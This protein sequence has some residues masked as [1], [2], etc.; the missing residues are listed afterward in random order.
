MFESQRMF[1]PNVELRKVRNGIRMDGV[2]ATQEYK[3]A[4]GRRISWPGVTTRLKK[5]P[6][7]NKE[8]KGRINTEHTKCYITHINVLLSHLCLLEV[9]P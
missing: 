5:Q 3:P 4:L 7:D 8:I 6:P 1:N 9:V 2:V